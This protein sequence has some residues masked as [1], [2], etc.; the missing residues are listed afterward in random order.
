VAVIGAIVAAENPERAARA[1]REALAAAL[2]ERMDTQTQTT[3]PIGA[4]APCLGVTVN[5]K[6]VEVAA[7]WT[8]HDFLASKRLSH[9]MALVELNG[10]ILARASLRGDAAAPGRHA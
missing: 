7:G 1:L 9:G 6:P 4:E 3:A 5:G 10:T 2:E 8:V